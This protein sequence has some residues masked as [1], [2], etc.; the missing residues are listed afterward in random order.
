MDFTWGF[1]DVTIGSTDVDVLCVNFSAG[2]RRVIV[3]YIR[4]VS[5]RCIV[6]VSLQRVIQHVVVKHCEL[7]CANKNLL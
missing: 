5:M 3:Q 6:C 1:A 7:K 4:T 2:G